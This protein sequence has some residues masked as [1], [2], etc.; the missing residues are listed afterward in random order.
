MIR[1]L[2]SSGK[3]PVDLIL[4]PLNISDSARVKASEIQNLSTEMGRSR[5]DQ[6]LRREVLVLVWRLASILLFEIPAPDPVGSEL[7]FDICLYI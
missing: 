3:F 5:S 6:S 4:P 7:M 2:K 1:W